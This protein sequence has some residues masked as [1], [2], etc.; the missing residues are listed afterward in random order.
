MS[1][2]DGGSE[3]QD[4]DGFRVEYR[5]ASH[6]YWIHQPLL[7]NR[8][9]AVSVTSVLGLLDKPALRKWYGAQDATAVLEL[10]R[11]GD[12]IGIPSDK[13]I[14]VARQKG[15]GAE[16]KRDAGASR[17]T[18]VHDA[19]RAY[20]EDGTVPALGDFPESVRGYVQGVCS[21]LVEAA[22]EPLMTE[23]IV[24][25]PTQ[26]FAGRFDLLATI[27]G[28]RT[29]VDLKT[30][31]SIHPEMHLQL[32]GYQLA[33]AECDIE[34]VERAIILAAA[35]SGHFTTARCRAKPA[36]FLAVL[37]AHRE[38]KALES[39]ISAAKREAAKA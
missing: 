17:G 10:E 32:A 23:R 2:H 36:A 7:S 6:R 8:E 35:E 21:W 15:V 18:A 24:G 13:A 38:V 31:S 19:L 22:P 11:E 30:S 25:S 3:F 39:E 34:P 29:L 12:L 33:F 26:L 5:D 14:Y 1:F 9:S 20:C 27:D 37:R 16:A 4:Y 28:V